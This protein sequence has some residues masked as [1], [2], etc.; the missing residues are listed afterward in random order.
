MVV[1]SRDQQWKTGNPCGAFNSPLVFSVDNHTARFQ[2]ERNG[3]R[4][5]VVVEHYCVATQFRGTALE[6]PARDIFHLASPT[7]FSRRP[8]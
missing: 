6:H 2:R 8:C 4:Y 1:K 5:R 3:G 7:L